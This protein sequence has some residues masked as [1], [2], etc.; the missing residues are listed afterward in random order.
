MIVEYID[1]ESPYLD[2]VEELYNGIVLGGVK[3]YVTPT[4]VCEVLYTS[5]RV[6]RRAGVEDPNLE[7]IKFLRWFLSLAGV[8][9]LR[10][11]DE[12]AML[13]G[14]LKKTLK[15]SVV[16][17][18]LI[19]AAMNRGVPALFLKLEEEM[20]PYREKLVELGV[21]YLVETPLDI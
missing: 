9:R 13:A 7:A 14:E 12:T 19:A 20:K 15:L 2:T 8:Q 10:I 21:K 6:Y 4:T 3:A 11:T 16:D 5:Y 18:M 1:E 17:C